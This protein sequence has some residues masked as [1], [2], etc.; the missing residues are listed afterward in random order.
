MIRKL[1]LFFWAIMF[2]FTAYSQKNQTDEINKIKKSRNYLYVTGTSM[3]SEKEANDNAMI[4][5]TAEIEAW[6]KENSKGK[7]DVTGYTA[8]A[9]KNAGFIQTKIG[10]LYRT[11]AYVKKDDILLFY[12]DDIII[13]NQIGDTA[14][15]Q[16]IQ[17]T[18]PADTIVAP[19]KQPQ[20][21]KKDSIAAP[22]LQPQTEKQ[23]SVVAPTL[24]PQTEKQ[25]S[26]VAPTLQPQI[27]KKDS[28]AT[29]TLQPQTENISEKDKNKDQELSEKTIAPEVAEKDKTPAD[30]PETKLSTGKTATQEDE[31]QMLDLLSS[32]AVKKY[33]NQKKQNDELDRFGQITEIPEEGTVYLFL[34]DYHGIVRQHIRITDGKAFDLKTEESVSLNNISKEF[35]TK[36]SI[37]FTIK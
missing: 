29:P 19:A 20:I 9:Q 13:N 4:M 33:L 28:I 14:G 12:K 18:V 8:K 11:F 17:E 10:S 16:N 30:T 22:T 35:S 7:G 23:D 21:A 36:Y 37:W 5:L 32:N 27:V 34:A 2:G 25:D 3:T 1:F 26:V 31:E 6:L 24:Q 15:N